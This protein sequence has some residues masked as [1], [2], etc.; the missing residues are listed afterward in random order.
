[1]TSAE[2][3]SLPP[4]KLR[5]SFEPSTL[6]RE[7]RTVEI[8]WTTGAKVLRGYWDKFW[9]ELS[10][11][12]AHVHLE[13]LNNG[14]PFLADHNGYRVADTPGV[15][16][17]AWLAKGSDGLPVGRA[18]IRFVKAG[19][20]AEADKLFE[21]IADAI[22][23]NVSVG[24]RVEKMEKTQ[25]TEGE[26]PVFRVVSWTPY[27]ISAVAMGADDGAG[28]RSA[29]QTHN[30]VE[31]RTTN[32][33]D[34]TNQNQTP[35]AL[36][37]ERER[38]ALAE[39]QRV[40][41]ITDI[42]RRHALVNLGDKLV[43]DGTPL[44]R[45]RVLILDA[46][47]ERS[48]NDGTSQA[49]SGA[50]E[51][52]SASGTRG[53]HGTEDRVRNMAAALAS[54]A[55]VREK[56]TPDAEQYARL[57]MVDMARICVEARGESTRL[58]GPAQI[59]KRA[60][61][62]STDLFPALLGEAGNRVLLDG[63]TSY[64]GGI[65]QISRA[66]SARDF[67]SKSLLRLGEAPE[68]LKVPEHGEIKHGTLS[69]SKASYALETFAR[70]FGL[71]RQAIINDDLG[72]FEMVRLYGRAAAELE[73][74]LLC[75]LLTSNPMM[76]D[77]VPLFHASHGNLSAVGSDISI[78]SLGEALAAMRTQKNLSGREP[79]NVVP[80]FIVCPAAL[81]VQALQHVAQ[82]QAAQTANVNPFAGDLRLTVVVDPRLD[83]VSKK[84]WYVAANPNVI[85]TLEHSYLDGTT[86]PEIVQE[87]G[88]DVDG[89]RWKARMDFGCAVIG[90]E[91]LY[92][93][94][95]AP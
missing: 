75:G 83:M 8:T 90:H 1:M 33:S 49:P 53:A 5:G 30:P 34:P 52:Y 47:A 79:L 13:R 19:T 73:A 37:A 95:G 70:I 94:I 11:D 15:V 60:A 26:V 22:V 38:A 14:A 66:S 85:P 56:L 25:E 16:E 35:D 71:T 50:V 68:L 9:E 89:T 72:A 67:R 42:T 7:A 59:L 31:V 84:A 17:R 82:L 10:L 20:D 74:K 45:A 54:R 91:G 2:T 43:K 51:R 41:T 55:G 64:P 63:Y 48:D 28:F 81:E 58:M 32:M 36:R 57:S 29:D 69:S 65:K 80:A 93:N 62:H 4:L 23:A 6:D 61:Y 40:S 46:L 44:D 27:E 21:K 77:G 39:R 87:E 92:K 78:T 24:Y 88:F 18:L 86:G 3:R 76:A 12:P